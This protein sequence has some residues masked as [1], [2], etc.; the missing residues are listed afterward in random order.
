MLSK[1]VILGYIKRPGLIGLVV[2]LA[3]LLLAVI[4]FWAWPKKTFSVFSF[5]PE[6]TIFYYQ[7]AT[8]S[9]PMVN[10]VKDKNIINYQAWLDQDRFLQNILSGD[11]SKIKDRLWF[12]TANHLSAN[13]WLLV[14]NEPVSPLIKKLKKD[15]PD[16]YYRQ[17]ANNILAI[18]NQTEAAADISDQPNTHWDQMPNKVGIN[19]Y[20]HTDKSWPVLDPLAGWLNTFVDGPE[21]YLN[22]YSRG[23]KKIIK[24]SQP[25]SGQARADLNQ[26]FWESVPIP[27]DFELALGYST[28][29]ADNLTF[30]KEYLIK[31][32]FQSLPY[33]SL[34]GTDQQLLTGGNLVLQRG[35]DWLIAGSSD[36]QSLLIDL[37]SQLTLAERTKTLSDGTKYTELMAEKPENVSKHDYRD[38]QY[39]QFDNLFGWQSNTT[40]YVGNSQLWLEQF[41]SR[42]SFVSDWWNQC[43]QSEAPKIKD[44][45]I[46]QVDK[47]PQGAIKDYLKSENIGL[48]EIF[49]LSEEQSRGWQLC[50]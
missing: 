48:L 26:P 15:Q 43:D 36:W 35:P 9:D 17:L 28:D 14:L 8:V 50:F 20:W 10:W 39:W 45:M 47:L 2:A 3:V 41:I 5:L 34:Y 40:Y 42:S 21:F 25:L 30:I 44:F 32:I 19:I 23:N 27:T 22:F 37:A 29:S 11:Y 13:S 18:S 4:I 31:P 38:Q 6:D 16:Y 1:A 12:K 49:G 24:L 7:P 46:W 33:D